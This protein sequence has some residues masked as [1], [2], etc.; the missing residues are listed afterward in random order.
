MRP[1]LRLHDYGE[2]VKLMQRLL[3]ERGL[4]RMDEITG[5]FD[6]NTLASLRL[7]QE[8]EE[9]NPSGICDAE[10]WEALGETLNEKG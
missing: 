10:T 3:A 2:E 8:D 4:M 6:H 7:F 9:L 5:R 1:L